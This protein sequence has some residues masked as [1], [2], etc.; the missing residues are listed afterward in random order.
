MIKIIDTF[1]QLGGLFEDNTFQLERWEQYI[2]SIYEGCAE[3]FKD[4]MNEYLEGGE[5]TYEKDFLPIIN[6]VWKNPKLDIL[7]DSFLAVTDQLD[8]KI[9]ECFGV[10]LDVEIVLYLGLCNAA[11]WVTTMNG[12]DVVMLG[13]E[14]I[15]EL[16][17]HELDAMYGLV[18]HELGHIYHK[19]FGVLERHSDDPRR[20]FVWQLFTEGIAMYYEQALVGNFDF[21]HQDVNGWKN[22]CDENFWQIA[23]DFCADLP[24]M[25]RLNQRYF[26][27]WVNYHGY[28]DVG[29]Y[30]GT[31]FVHYLLESHEL[32]RLIHMEITEVYET[33]VKFV[34]IQTNERL[35]S[36]CRR[37]GIL[38]KIHTTDDP[39]E[40]KVQTGEENEVHTVTLN[41][42]KI[43]AEEYD[44]YAGYHVGTILLPK[45]VLE[46]E[47]LILRRYR[48]EDAEDCFAF[49]SNEQD[50]YMDCCRAFTAMD[51]EFY[52]RVKLFGQR[53][54]QYMITLKDSGEVIGT[55]NV[56]A[57]DARAV[58]AKE[59]GYSIAP[60]HQRKGYA[61]EALS[62]L[63]ALLQKEL[64]LEMV[65]AGILPENVASEKLLAKLGFRKEG[66]RHKAVWHEGLDNPVDLV[67]YYRDR[68]QYE[69][70]T[71]D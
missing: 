2:N 5:Y 46:T 26:G 69:E 15:L 59:I 27:D 1:P 20:D 36:L 39:D 45:L 68:D 6:D 53:E 62:A 70:N 25:T 56:F 13:V 11:G 54:T 57:D 42:T 66:L 3:I 30:L 7:H 64:C 24:T 17:W 35:E 61:F 21:Y 19:Q 18:Y 38:L 37:N 29:Y 33:F 63:L 67:Y 71:N 14:K 23:S 58:D 52:E 44:A 31:R 34:H 22:W 60:A 12:K 10:E 49:L 51:E 9:R 50:A 55:V 47:R 4:D 43:P 41:T 32:S 40:P 16:N 48:E 65:T 8:R 28:G